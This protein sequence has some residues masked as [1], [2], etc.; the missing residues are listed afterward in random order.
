MT[1]EGPL[2]RRIAGRFGETSPSHVAPV[3]IVAVYGTVWIA[4]HASM[5]ARMHVLLQGLALLE[6][7]SAL[8]LRRRKPIGALVGIVAISG[9]FQL[10]ALLFPAIVLAVLTAARYSGRQ[11]ALLA[12]ACTAAAVGVLPNLAARASA[13]FV[14]Y[15]LPHVLAVLLA[16][17]LGIWA[18]TRTAATET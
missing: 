5:Q 2:A 8:L 1:S 11:T 7:V 6:T 4:V 13:G 16:G 14:G 12:T 10:E 9:L 18:G 3:L 17:A 15:T